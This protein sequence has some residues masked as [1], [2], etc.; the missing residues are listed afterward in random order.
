MERSEVNQKGTFLVRVEGDTSKHG[1]EGGCTPLREMLPA[2]IF[3]SLLHNILVSVFSMGHRCVSCAS[4]LFWDAFGAR[5][6][7]ATPAVWADKER[8]IPPFVRF[9]CFMGCAWLGRWLCTLIWQR[10]LVHG[11]D[12]R[13][14]PHKQQA[15]SWA[16]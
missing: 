9:P 14:L 10:P 6:T 2:S 16:Y 4:E 5:I 11:C 8:G 7:V 1:S 12:G 15:T 3:S 13:F